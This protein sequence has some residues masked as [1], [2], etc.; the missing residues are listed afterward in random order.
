MKTVIIN[1]TSKPFTLKAGNAG[2][3]LDIFKLESKAQYPIDVDLN[4]TYREYMA[5]T[6]S[7]GETLLFA[8]EVKDYGT[9]TILDDETA[10]QKYRL[11][12]GNPRTPGTPSLNSSSHGNSK[13]LYKLRGMFW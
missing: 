5:A 6:G 3:F 4:A 7:K 8:E 12:F 9:I 13:W 1:N 11:E 10:P 2:V